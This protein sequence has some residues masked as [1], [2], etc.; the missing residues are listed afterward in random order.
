MHYIN[1]TDGDTTWT[2]TTQYTQSTHYSTLHVRDDEATK[3]AY[4]R[5]CAAELMS[6][7]TRRRG[8]A[9][10]AIVA[11]ACARWRRTQCLTPPHSAPCGV[12]GENAT[13]SDGAAERVVATHAPGCMRKHRAFLSEMFNPSH[14]A[15]VHR[16][17]RF[18]HTLCICWW[19][20]HVTHTRTHART[21]KTV[22]ARKLVR[23]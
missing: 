18:L 16:I 8:F 11:R 12:L 5:T 13:E 4:E 10:R 21:R 3:R 23:E 2:T 14:Q 22:S 19:P 6:G 1:I 17:Q 20:R 15:H 7:A 9:A